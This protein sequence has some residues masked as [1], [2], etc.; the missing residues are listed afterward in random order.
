M[1]TLIPKIRNIERRYSPRLLH[2]LV[3]SVRA[4]VW[5]CDARTFQFTFVSQMAEQILGYPTALWVSD[6]EFWASH[7]HPDDRER[8][9][10]LCTESTRQ[11]QDHEFEY[12][13]IAADGRTVSL[14][15][16]V[17]VKVEAGEAT[18]LTGV[19]IDISEQKNT[20]ETLRLSEERFFKAFRSNP[21]SIAI[22][23][24]AEGRFLEVN[25]ALLRALGYERRQ[26]V[27]KTGA[28]LALWANPEERND[29]IRA[30]DA[31]DPVLK[32]GASFRTKSGQIREFEISA[33]T[34][35]VQGEP[36]LLCFA[37]D[38]TDQKQL[39]GQLRQ[40]GKMDAMG[41]F[42]GG[43]AHDFNNLLGIMLGYCE[44][45]M[46]R[47]GTDDANRVKVERILEAGE[48]AAGLTRQLLA[49]SRQQILQPEILNMNVLVAEAE[50]LLHRLIGEDIELVVRPGANICPVMADSGQIIQ[51]ILNLAVNARDAMPTGGKLSIETANVEVSPGDVPPDAD[52]PQPGGPH[53]VLSVRDAGVGMDAETQAHIFEPFFTTKQIGKG[54]GLGLATVYGIVKQSGG[55]IR[56]ESALGK[57]TTFSVYLPR[58]ASALGAAGS[59]DASDACSPGT[60]TI[61]LVEDEEALRRLTRESLEFAGYNVV[62]AQ[63][64]DDAL[65]VVEK[66]PG[67]IHLLLTDV[68][69]P[70]MSGPELTSRLQAMVPGLRTIYVSGYSGSKL[71]EHGLREAGDAFLQKPYPR[72]ALLSAIRQ[73]LNK[74]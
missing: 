54:T 61:L 43:V 53:V 55:F 15:D 13:M 58:I 1:A 69:M 64:G 8:V 35:P 60:E 12:R 28:E 74:E 20:Q 56:V 63:D 73:A 5:R 25:D 49:F 70:N 34:I 7:I 30:L 3:D 14:K 10:R 23:T 72:H 32:R 38:V 62:E 40:A 52:T 18:E 29:L 16:I 39:E 21:E 37:H 22:T 50:K 17:N 27:G 59:A 71:V 36:C 24:V 31:G 42:A 44:L 19:M 66:H 2:D 26:V 41:Q 65:R 46:E 48:R 6:P 4:I 57:G 11:L 45:L 68:V 33:E 47:L 9:V 67:R 51:V